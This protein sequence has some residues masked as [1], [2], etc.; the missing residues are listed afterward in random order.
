[1]RHLRNGVSQTDTNHIKKAATAV[2]TTPETVSCVRAM[3]TNNTTPK[4]RTHPTIHRW[5]AVQPGNAI[6]NYGFA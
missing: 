1:V 3:L 5:F 4:I 6:G 2:I